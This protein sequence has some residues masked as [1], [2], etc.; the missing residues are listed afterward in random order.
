MDPWVVA[1]QVQSIISWVNMRKVAANVIGLLKA[2]EV[3]FLAF[4]LRVGLVDGLLVCVCAKAPV[5]QGDG[6]VLASLFVGGEPVLLAQLGAQVRRLLVRA[7]LTL[8][9]LLGG[10]EALLV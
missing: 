6:L 9:V 7:Q 4:A 2:K 5:L 8:L 1:H 3:R 10:L